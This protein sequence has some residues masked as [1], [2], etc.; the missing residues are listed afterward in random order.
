MT[1]QCL[2]IPQ[3]PLLEITSPRPSSSSAS[4]PS[5]QSLSSSESLSSRSF[6]EILQN[7]PLS[8]RQQDLRR[9]NLELRPVRTSRTSDNNPAPAPL[10]PPSSDSSQDPSAVSSA[11]TAAPDPALASQQSADA[12]SSLSGSASES[13]PS[14][15]SSDPPPDVSPSNASQTPVL[16]ASP[17]VGPR[18]FLPVDFSLPPQPPQTSSPSPL[19]SDAA[20]LP[21]PSTLPL[22]PAD[23]SSLP[24]PVPTDSAAASPSAPSSS[25]PASQRPVFSDPLPATS[26]ST[27]SIPVTSSSSSE[28]A[29]ASVPSIQ[30][31]AVS[32]SF[33]QPHPLQPDLLSD[34]DSVSSVSDSSVSD[35]QSPAPAGPPVDLAGRF[36]DFSVPS[37]ADSSA[38]LP[39]VSSPA[40]SS[41]S[42]VSDTSPQPASSLP[43]QPPLDSPDDPQL[44]LTAARVARGLETALAQGG[45]TVRLHLH[46][47]EL[48]TV[49][50]QMHVQDGLVRASFT[51]TNPTVQM[52]LS[53]RLDQLRLALERHGMTVDRLDVHLQPPAPPLQTSSSDGSSSW[54]AP[55]DGRSRGS[56]AGGEGRSDQGS[57]FSRNSRQAFDR[58]DSPDPPPRPISQPLLNL[59]G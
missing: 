15:V 27:P 31:A 44:Q 35:K 28:P 32:P 57:D 42:S 22:I 2:Q 23:T 29:G 5:S 50:I 14:P 4:T 48:G 7:R 21:L 59:L 18:G 43:T 38:S 53:H 24:S 9:S 39:P 3:L 25:S 33:P 12:S 8:S 17:T 41:S 58:D 56:F 36:A 40:A 30:P 37:F 51:T 52:L 13:L 19:D 1:T 34:S 6:R 11:D 54:S 26:S 10:N 46:P 47:P 55:E 16:P 20:P 49:R 45:G